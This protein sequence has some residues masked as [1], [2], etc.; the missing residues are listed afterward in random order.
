MQLLENKINKFLL[1]IKEVMFKEE[2]GIILPFNKENFAIGKVLIGEYKDEYVLFPR[3][4]GT[5][6]EQGGVE[7]KI[8]E[9]RDIL[10]FVEPSEGEIVVDF[11]EYNTKGNPDA[12]W[13][14]VY[15]NKRKI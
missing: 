11:I 8:V 15:N 3:H 7:C 10:A 2:K 5:K 14:S 13:V 12:E 4:I 1:T 9:Y 6:I